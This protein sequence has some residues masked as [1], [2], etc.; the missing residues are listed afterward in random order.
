MQENSFLLENRHLQDLNP[1]I[2]GTH[3]CDPG[4][5]IQPA[6]RKYTLI[7]YVFRGKGTLFNSQGAHPVQAG[8]AFLIHQ[9]EVANYQADE[10][11]PWYY[12]WIGFDG[13]LSA[14]F[15]ALP[16]VISPSESYFLKIIKAA[17]TP[18]VAEYLMSAELFRLYAELF[19]RQSHQNRHVRQVENYIRLSYM[20]P[21]R[22][23]NIAKQLNL[24][25]RYLSRLFK[26]ETGV[27]IQDFLLSTRMEEADR[28]LREGYSVKESAH[29]A[30][31]DDVSNFSKLYKK[32][33]GLSP[34]L[35]RKERCQPE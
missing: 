20:Y 35:R 22:V 29:L 7:H 21:I 17:Q 6:V 3:D 30:G 1:L 27:T 18:S 28:R 9:N 4:Y 11:D 2:A 26:E 14:Q 12:C 25:R 16:S 8:Q 34:A 24:D 33:F 10:S 31:Y 19:H 13:A 23:E 32:H 15:D 5:G